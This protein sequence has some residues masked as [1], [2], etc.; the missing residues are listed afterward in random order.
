MHLV[1]FK[2][3][4]YISCAAIFN[5]MFVQLYN[6]VLDGTDPWLI[7]LGLG[8]SGITGVIALIIAK[9]KLKQGQY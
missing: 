7:V 4:T 8:T 9:K 3:K 5:Q 6:I 2:V 1:L